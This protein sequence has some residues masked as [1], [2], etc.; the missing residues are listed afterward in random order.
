MSHQ[1]SLTLDR[2]LGQRA[3]FTAELFQRLDR[4][5]IFAL[6]EPR[7]VNGTL[8]SSG[9]RLN[10]VSGSARGVEFML[11][12][13]SANRFAGWL[14]YAYLRTGL[15][16]STTGL[17]FPA[18]AD[19][20]NS[21]RVFA[22]YRP[23]S[24]W[25]F[26]ALWRYGSGQPVTGFFTKRGT[27]YFRGAQRNAVRLPAYSRLDLRASKNLTLWRSQW[28]FS[29]EGANILNRRN[30][31]FSGIQSIDAAGKVKDSTTAFLGRFIAIGL[32]LQF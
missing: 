11:Q 28:T 29:I 21:F 17:R 13:R 7:F 26:G 19:Q 22:N 18:D 32:V 10:S 24:S 8:A 23:G 3:R 12:R 16:E 9:R 25:N 20:R 5:R 30:L 2:A 4:S 27:D 1:T 15:T 31:A 6:N 14:S